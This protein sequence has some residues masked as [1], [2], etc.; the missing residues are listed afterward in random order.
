MDPG[1]P[2]GKDASFWSQSILIGELSPGV[3]AAIKKLLEISTMKPGWDGYRSASISG[4][5][6]EGA[7]SL[8]RMI[9]GLGLPPPR[10]VPVPGGG[11][12]VEFTKAEKELEIEL[13]PSGQI[14]FLKTDSEGDEEEGRL[15]QC[16]P[17]LLP[18]LVWLSE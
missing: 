4:P 15:A 12:Q 7:L 18:L 13:E 6:R 14:A 2:S 3:E 1:A 10:V 11:I 5:A 17:K 16:D 9:D 8:L